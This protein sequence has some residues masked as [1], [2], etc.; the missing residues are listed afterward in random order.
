MNQCDV[1]LV[2]LNPTKGSEIQKTRPCVIVSDDAIGVLPLRVIVPFTDWKEHYRAVSW[3]VN[4]VPSVMNGLQKESAADCFQVRSVSNTRFIRKLGV[5]DM[6]NFVQIQ[7]AL[8]TVFS[9]VV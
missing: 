6:A 9:I 4:V 1:W 8:A 7:G 5:I 2:D 3:L